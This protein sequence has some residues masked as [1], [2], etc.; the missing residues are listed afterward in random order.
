MLRLVV[1]VTYVHILVFYIYTLLYVPPQSGVEILGTARC[2]ACGGFRRAA[3]SAA[4]V[5]HRRSGRGST[6]HCDRR[7]VPFHHRRVP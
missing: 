1:T 6:Y 2:T 3:C 7:L 4:G 5:Y